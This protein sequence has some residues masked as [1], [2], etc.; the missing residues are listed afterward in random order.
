MKGSAEGKLR[1]TR[2]NIDSRLKE[3]LTGVGKN[4]LVLVALTGHGQQLPVK[5]LDGS[6]FEDGFY[7]PV[8]A[9]INEPST[10][11][12]LSRLTDETLRKWGGK[13]LVLVDACRD[14][15][16]DN[17]KGVARGIQGKVV[18]LP[19]GTAILFACAGGQRSLERESLKHG[20]FTFGVLE[21]MR[22]FDGSSGPLTWGSLVDRVQNTVA[23][24]NSEQ[25]PILAGSMGRLELAMRTTVPGRRSRALAAEGSK[26]GDLRDDNFLKM[27]FRWCPPGK[28]RMGSPPD[29]PSRSPF[30]GPVDV[31]LRRGF[32]MGQFEVT[33]A[34]WQA[35]MG[36][37]LCDQMARA[38]Q[39]EVKGEGSDLPVYCVDHTEAT[40]FSSRLTETERREGRLPDGWSYALPTEARWEYACRAGTTT[41]T[42]FGASL[43]SRQANFDGNNP[44]GGA[45]KGPYLQETAPVGR[46]PANAWGLCDMHGN[47]WEWCS[48]WYDRQLVDGVDP[49]G[50]L[51]GND[52][53]IRGGG[54]DFGARGCRSADRDGCDPALRGDNVLGF[55]VARVPSG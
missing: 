37:S 21:A 43:R 1:A 9:V 24:L 54:W 4:D 38:G 17:D 39:T 16:K 34:Q 33:Q 32:W 6:S 22:G 27:K 23:E 40:E 42:A 44:Y 31:T 35:V 12:S 41:A 10:L 20:V 18:A 50:P 29:E 3:L 26:A 47:V 7:C 55:R 28:F 15:V 25:E 46:Y 19:E 11:V 51:S 30:E 52:R 14:G 5:R 49:R 8:D 2:E 53:V 36:T 48:D 45:E 13:N